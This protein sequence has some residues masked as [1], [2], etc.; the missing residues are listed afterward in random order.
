M[1]AKVETMLKQDYISST[2]YSM[3]IQIKHRWS[4]DFG[5]DVGMFRL[6]RSITPAHVIGRWTLSEFLNKPT[7]L[8]WAHSAQQRD[9]CRPFLFACIYKEWFRYYNNDPDFNFRHFFANPVQITSTGPTTIADICETH[10][11][12]CDRAAALLNTVRRGEDREA[13]LDDLL[14]RFPRNHNFLPLCRAILIVFDEIFPTG[15]ADILL[16]KESQR[17]NVLVVRTKDEDGLSASI[18]FDAI[19]SQSLPL[20]RSDISNDHKDDIIRV[21]LRTAVHF[22]LDLQRREEIAFPEVS[23]NTSIV[24]V[25]ADEHV[26]K[27]MRKV[28]KKGI[29]EVP[30]MT[31]VLARMEE[32]ERG[33]FSE[34]GEFSFWSPRWQ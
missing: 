1:R 9:R 34:S 18:N 11:C 25:E 14:S 17:Q 31:S 24:S 16:D 32:E 26:A 33:E 15:S 30:E 5:E 29:K 12:L 4:T 3:G 8:Y 10:K 28:E 21:S 23:C 27:V 22:V 13:H 6:K 19:R 7:A 2:N 20:A